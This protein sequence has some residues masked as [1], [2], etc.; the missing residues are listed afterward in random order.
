M[1]AH[2]ATELTPGLT[3]VLQAYASSTC[4]EEK[5]ASNVGAAG[6]P[7][8]AGRYHLLD[9]V[10]RG[11]MGVV[12][13]ARDDTL[14]RELAIKISRLPEPCGVR[15]FL[16]EAQI[17]SQLQHPGIVPVYDI[18]QLGDQRPFFAM[19][20]VE[21]RTLADLLSDRPSPA[22]DLPR[23]LGLFQQTC[24]TLAYAHSREVI[25]RDLKPANI[26]LGAYGEVLIMDWG[27][28]KV[29]DDPV[30]SSDGEEEVG[31][32][33]SGSRPHTTRSDPD[34]A[35]SR[36]GTI[37]GTPAY[38]GARAST[39][40]SRSARCPGRRVRPGRDPCESSPARR[41]MTT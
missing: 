11:G 17:V 9:Q 29:L 6:M 2:L 7:S 23:F 1:N 8:T 31:H 10:G 20:L 18:G 26:M 33:E 19:K 4:A 28:A 39:R 34:T 21:G 5:P 16:A 36:P 24:Q 3:A 25:H 12:Y 13:R 15:R 22:T 38:I 32:T 37:V 35:V 41:P 14:G 27:L 30:A 40:R